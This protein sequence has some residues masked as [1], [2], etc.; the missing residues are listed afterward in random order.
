MKE[1]V[2]QRYRGTRLDPLGEQIPKL[3]GV[4]AQIVTRGVAV[5]ANPGAELLAFLEELL[6]SHGGEIKIGRR[7]PPRQS[8]LAERTCEP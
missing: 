8:R 3:R 7:P 1:L 4:P 2:F 6:A 5:F